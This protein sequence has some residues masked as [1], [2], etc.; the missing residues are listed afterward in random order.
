LNDL[1]DQGVLLH[2]VVEKKQNFCQKE[3]NPEGKKFS[4][5]IQLIFF[6]FKNFFRS[7]IT[8]IFD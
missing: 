3:K 4:E 6:L 8:S 7:S 1:L 2:C 5:K